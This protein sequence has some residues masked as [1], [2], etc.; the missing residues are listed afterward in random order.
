VS[1][2]A[3]STPSAMYLNQLSFGGEFDDPGYSGP[4]VTKIVG[5]TYRQLDYWARTDLVRPSITDASGS[6]SR[7]RY[8]FGDLIIL[9]LVK[10][11]LDAGNSLQAAR[12]AIETILAAGDQIEQT[13]LVLTETGSILART[14]AAIIDLLRGGQGMLF[15]LP[16]D[17]ILADVNEGLERLQSV[18]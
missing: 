6:G 16:I 10:K 3:S 11:I 18:G 1:Q 2:T 14:D 13:H 4:Q 7:R 15:I 5:I 9:R 17:G 12:R 8:S